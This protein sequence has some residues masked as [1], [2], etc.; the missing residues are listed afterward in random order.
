M[1]I[2][3]H[4]GQFWNQDEDPADSL[5]RRLQEGEFGLIH[6]SRDLGGDADVPSQTELHFNLQLIGVVVVQLDDLK[7]VWAQTEVGIELAMALFDHQST[8]SLY[9]GKTGAP[10]RGHDGVGRGKMVVVEYYVWVARRG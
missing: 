5:R 8:V 9:E 7:G 1:I 3:I 10:F 6:L 2:V 4:E